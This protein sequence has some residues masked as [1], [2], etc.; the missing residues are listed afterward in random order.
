MWQLRVFLAD[1]GSVKASMLLSVEIPGSPLFT[2]TWT[3]ILLSHVL[4]SNSVIAAEH[5]RTM[6]HCLY[7]QK[8]E[9]NN[10]VKQNA[11]WQGQ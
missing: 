2:K 7:L 5:L 8:I 6:R 4:L 9:N 3:F 10:T 1:G 11:P